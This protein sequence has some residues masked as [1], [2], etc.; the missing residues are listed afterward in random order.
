[1]NKKQAR[2]K[3]RKRFSIATIL[4]KEYLRKLRTL[5]NQIDAIIK[6]LVNKSWLPESTVVEQTLRSYSETIKPWAQSVAQTMVE[7]ITDKDANAWT[8]LS[9]EIGKNLRREINTAPTGQIMREFMDEQ[10][11]LITS[12]P[13]DAASKVHELTL[14]G[15]VTGRRAEDIK[16]DVLKLGAMTENRAK[17]IART[18]VA[19]TA[20]VLTQARCN[21]VGITHYV[22]ETCDDESVRQSHKEMNGKIVAWAE[23]PLLSDGTRTHAGQFINCRCY[24]SPIVP[25]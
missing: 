4:E 3:A 13:L 21:H 17:M 5:T 24:P 12:L 19:R 7:R 22:W 2:R 11:R 25:D 8:Q 16:R 18:E 1:M 20:S 6:G 14:E 23:T 9:N 15:I 10:V